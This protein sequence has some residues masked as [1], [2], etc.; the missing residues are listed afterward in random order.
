MKS[1]LIID[2]LQE[3]ADAGAGVMEVAVFVAIDL[4]VFQRLHEGFTGRVGQGSQ[5]QLMA[6]LP[7]VVLKSPIHI[8]R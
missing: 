3:L 6:T 4:F 8:I 2:T 1:F 7:T 5:L